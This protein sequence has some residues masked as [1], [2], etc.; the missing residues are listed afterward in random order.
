MPITPTPIA[1]V[2]QAESALL[3]LLRAHV[4]QLLAPLHMPS[5]DVEHH[6]RVWGHCAQ[7]LAELHAHGL[8]IDPLLIRDAMI[9]CMF[10]DVGLLHD[11]GPSH[12]HHSAQLC[13]NYLDAHGPTEAT[14]RSRILEAIARHDDKQLRGHSPLAPTDMLDLNCM[15]ATADDLDAAGHIGVLRYTE[16]YRLR[17]IGPD[18]LPQLA[19]ANLAARRANMLSAYAPL[20]QFCLHHAARFD[21][22]LALF[23]QMPQQTELLT[24]ICTHLVEA[25]QPVASIARQAMHDSTLPPPVAHYLQGLLREL[26]IHQP[27][28]SCNAPM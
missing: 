13:A 21:T 28:E 9:A 20:A 1:I 10:H 17:G 16:I 3:P 23:G 24:W 8:H 11:I 12:G 14:S 19:H 26:D 4:A 15:V 6:L 7:L 18:Q 2:A 25:R 5:H 27:N 22:A